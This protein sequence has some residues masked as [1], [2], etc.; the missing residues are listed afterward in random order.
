MNL[1]LYAN[2]KTDVGETVQRVIESLVPQNGLEIYR[3]LEGLSDKLRQPRYSSFV[4]VLLAARS[5]DLWALMSIRDL[6]NDIPII[7]IL[8][9][10]EKDT[11]LTAHKFYPRYVTDVRGDFSDVALVI[12][13]IFKNAYPERKIAIEQSETKRSSVR[14]TIFQQLDTK[15][16]DIQ[17]V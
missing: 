16:G 2:G 10:S 8:P 7:F 3:T 15:G 5:E 17:N 4:M 12:K 9:D 11:V 1:V 13:K 6:F 14:K